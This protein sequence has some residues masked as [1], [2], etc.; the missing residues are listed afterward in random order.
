MVRNHKH[1]VSIRKR[2]LGI[3]GPKNGDVAGRSANVR[4]MN[5][6]KPWVP[7]VDVLKPSIEEL[8]EI[9]E[10]ALA[11]TAVSILAPTCRISIV[12]SSIPSVIVAHSLECV[13]VYRSEDLCKVFDSRSHVVNNV[14]AVSVWRVRAFVLEFH[15]GRLVCIGHNWISGRLRD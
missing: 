13:V 1:P 7:C 15:N 2:V 4:I 14:L 3:Y 12:H 10:V 5:R 8:G 9:T 11:E 6:S